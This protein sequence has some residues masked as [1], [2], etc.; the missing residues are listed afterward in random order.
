MGFEEVVSIR[1][2]LARRAKHRGRGSSAD[3][4]SKMAEQTVYC[5]GNGSGDYD[6]GKLEIRYQRREGTRHN[7]A[8]RK[9]ISMTGD[10]KQQ[11][12]SKN[13]DTCVGHGKGLSPRTGAIPSGLQRRATRGN[14]EADTDGSVVRGRQHENERAFGDVHVNFVSSR[15]LRMSSGGDTE[16]GWMAVESTA[17]ERMKTF[18]GDAPLSPKCAASVRGV[19]AS[20]TEKKCDDGRGEVW[21]P[22]ASRC[23]AIGQLRYTS[24]KVR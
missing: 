5:G 14:S 12:T 6:S 1:A 15:R 19:T 18:Q 2:R 13:R 11:V 22:A 20:D 4:H 16:G 7:M 23:E 3:V 17:I 8:K 9:P 10:R 24:M 21:K